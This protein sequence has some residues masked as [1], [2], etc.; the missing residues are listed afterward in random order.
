M[1][2]LAKQAGQLREKGV[3]VVAVQASKV[4]E[5]TLAEWVK[6]SNIAFP[7]G[8]VQGDPSATLGTGEEQTRSA[9][10]VQSLPWLILTDRE[11][12]VIAGGFGVDDLDERIKEADNVEH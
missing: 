10:G 9:W 12:V 1:T 8:M 7:V 11:H 5:T 6:N 4:D 2:Q 3:T